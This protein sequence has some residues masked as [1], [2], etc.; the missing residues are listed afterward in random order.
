MLLQP[1]CF[2]KILAESTYHE[3]PC[4]PLKKIDSCTMSYS[5]P[6]KYSFMEWNEVSLCSS[7]ALSVTIRHHYIEPNLVTLH[8]CLFTIMRQQSPPFPLTSKNTVKWN[9]YLILCVW[10]K[11]SLLL[12]K[13]RISGGYHSQR[14]KLTSTYL[15]S[16]N[17]PPQYHNKY[18]MTKPRLFSFYVSP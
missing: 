3:Y 12:P 15:L 11:T 17:R 4:L 1:I 13:W 2:L 7:L 18:V 16:G 6:N 8:V 5:F 10:Y 14:S 9:K